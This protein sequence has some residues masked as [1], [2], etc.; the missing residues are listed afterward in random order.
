MELFNI[1]CN[2]IDELYSTTRSNMKELNTRVFEQY[3]TLT[4]DE[5]FL[6][7]DNVIAR[8]YSS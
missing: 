3:Q 6:S 7:F 5:D 4:L 8:S 1:V 2:E